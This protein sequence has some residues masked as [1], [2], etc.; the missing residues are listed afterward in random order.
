MFR[1]LAG[2]LLSLALLVPTARAQTAPTG[3]IRPGAV[4]VRLSGAAGPAA[5]GAA[6]PAGAAVEARMGAASYALRVPAG[7]EERFLARLRALPQV[8]AAQLDR[9][10]AA[11]IEP[12][13]PSYAAQ[14]HLPRIG[15]PAAWAT[16][17]DT[18][19]LTVA[20]LDTGVKLDHPDLQGQLWAN[21]GE[22]PANGRDDD[23]DGFA[24]DVHGW[25]FYHVLSGGQSLPRQ[26]ADLADANGH[27]THVAGIIGA[28]GDN[29]LGVAG[30][31]WRA[32][33]M[34][35]RV[36]DAD[37]TG[38]ESDII[39]GLGY[40]VDHGARVVN[41]SLGL[42]SPGPLLAQAVA[43]A[44]ARGVVLVA[45]AGN[46]GGAV[47]YPAA[48][49][50]VIAVGASD[51]SD[52]RASF[53]AY[54]ARLDLLAPGVDILSTWNGRPYFAQSGTSMAA[55]QVAGVAAL[56][57]ARMP[58]AGPA[59]IRAC[60][61]AGAADLGAPGRDDTT[62]WGLLSAPGALRACAGSRLF[63]P[64]ARTS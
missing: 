59:A 9:R 31:A 42:A 54:G 60:L 44:Q 33:L 21:P 40:A 38:W 48:Y 49:P 11:Q 5:L 27:G 47:L 51:R 3:T 14:W 35:V 34:V 7:A 24:D 53:S 57:L 46:G 39:Q 52:A 15:M 10:V 62:G 8:A 29:G 2:A 37:A 23:G 6:L 43:D 22:L 36:L 20:V 32:R 1:H 55:P 56:L 50:G 19:G 26:D 13:D 58:R 30:V 25:H 41:M 61:L 16:I 4:L 17:T 45:A 64:L 18:A 12:D 63:L 28:A